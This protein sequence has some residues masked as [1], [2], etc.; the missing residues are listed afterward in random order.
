MS[1]LCTNFNLNDCCCFECLSFT[2]SINFGK[3]TLL[4]PS[5]LHPN[6]KDPPK[7]LKVAIDLPSPLMLKLQLTPLML[8]FSVRVLYLYK[9]NLNDDNNTPASH[10]QYI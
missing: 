10:K 9:K 8:K 6:C 7:L 3:T 4:P 2:G 5:N 1:W